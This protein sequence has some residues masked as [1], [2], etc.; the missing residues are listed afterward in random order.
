MTKIILSGC[1]GKMGRSIA[2]RLK[3]S[4]DIMI[5][6]GVDIAAEKYYSFP[7]YST[8]LDVAEDA[9]AIV[10]FS[11]HSAVGAISEFSKLKKIPVVFC[12]TGYTPEEIGVIENLSKEIAVFRSA[13]MSLGV[14]VLLGLCKRT[15]GILGDGFD[16]EITE[17]HHNQKL[18]APSGTAL[19][20]AD[21]INSAS[22]GKYEYVYDRHLKRAKRTTNEIG[23]HS[24]RGGN[25]VGEHSVI[26]AGNNEIL[27]LSHSALSREVFADGALKAA[28]FIASKAP[29]LYSM[30]DLIGD[31]L[32]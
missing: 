3:N 5:C 29:G 14:N 1:C 22:G 23:I 24:L 16:I 7:V 9:D 8:I 10:D 27:T 4:T 30:D 13:N 2:A 31:L 25:V 20:L 21:G 15:V 32:K 11:H 28:A 6:A 18:D 12:T 26:F 19:L 17:M